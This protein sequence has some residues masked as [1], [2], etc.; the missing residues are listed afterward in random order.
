MVMA[1]PVTS[2]KLSKMVG[3]LAPIHST[4]GTKLWNCGELHGIIWICFP[5]QDTILQIIKI[6]ISIV[7]NCAWKLAFLLSSHNYICTTHT[8]IYVA[9]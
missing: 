6:G 4:V 9:T 1:M 3:N 2:E 7:Y 8:H 5:F